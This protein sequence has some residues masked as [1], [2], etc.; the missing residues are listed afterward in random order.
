M[1]EIE[2]H[3]RAVEAFMGD[4]L[5]AVLVPDAEQLMR[6]IRYLESSGAGRGTFLPRASARTAAAVSTPSAR[7]RTVSWTIGRA[8]TGTSG[9]RASTGSPRSWTD[10]ATSAR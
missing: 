3:E 10:F 5:Q 9:K 2:A 6:G 4:R 8:D 7:S 1:S